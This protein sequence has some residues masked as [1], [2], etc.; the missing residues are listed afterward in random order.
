MPIRPATI[1]DLSAIQM[2]AE[3]L[4]QHVSEERMPV[5]VA[6][7]ME[8]F[9]FRDNAPMRLAV[10]EQDGEIVGMVS[11]MLHVELHCGRRRVFIGDLAVRKDAR[12]QKIGEALFHYVAEW[13]KK[14]Q[15]RKVVWEVW[16]HNETAKAFYSKRG[17]MVDSDEITYQLLLG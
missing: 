8:D 11:Y 6:T 7:E 16:R 12:R 4:A 15:A 9:F 3:Q 2:L 5:L 1:I 14:Q 17:G 13:G 10:Y